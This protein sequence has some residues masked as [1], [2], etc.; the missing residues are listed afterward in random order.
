M[1]SIPTS[2]TM[3]VKH[4]FGEHL[5]MGMRGGETLVSRGEVNPVKPNNYGQ[6]SHWCPSLNGYEAVVRL[7]LARNDVDSDKPA[8]DGQTPFW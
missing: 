8:N 5:G 3:M 2:P 1:K 6:M 7:V 4:Y